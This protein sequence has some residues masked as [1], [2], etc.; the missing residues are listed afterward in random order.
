MGRNESTVELL[1]NVWKGMKEFLLV[2]NESTGSFF[3]HMRVIQGMPR[4][5]VGRMWLYRLIIILSVHNASKIIGRIE[6]TKIK[7]DRHGSFA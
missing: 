7:I 5:M 4:S 6:K 2:P 1:V 3:R